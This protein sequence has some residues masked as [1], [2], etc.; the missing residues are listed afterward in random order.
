MY[1]A[2]KQQKIQELEG[3]VAEQD[4]Y[5]MKMGQVSHAKSSAQVCIILPG[6]HAARLCHFST[7]YTQL[8]D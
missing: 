1:N 3:L 4:D 6:H 7:L 2:L 8:L 5:I